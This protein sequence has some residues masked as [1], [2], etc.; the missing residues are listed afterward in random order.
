MFKHFSAKH[1]L[2]VCIWSE[3]VGL[4]S[5]MKLVVENWAGIVE[6]FGHSLVQIEISANDLRVLSVPF[7]IQN[8]TFRVV[9]LRRYEFYNYV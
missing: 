3:G 7:L 1:G 8:G 2:T 4:K 5:L 9:W 6:N